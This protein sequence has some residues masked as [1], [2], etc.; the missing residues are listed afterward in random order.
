ME[1]NT[2]ACS[3]ED[4]APRGGGARPV[5][6]RTTTVGRRA[7]PAAPRRGRK[8]PRVTAAAAER[9][10]RGCTARS[11]RARRRVPL[12]GCGAPLL[13]DRPTPSASTSARRAGARRTIAPRSSPSWPSARRLR[14][15][16]G[17]LL[18]VGRATSLLGVA[19]DGNAPVFVQD[20]CSS[21]A[22]ALAP[23]VPS[24]ARVLDA[25]AGRQGALLHAPDAH[26]GARPLGAQGARAAPALALERRRGRAPRRMR[27]RRR[28]GGWWDN[29]PPAR[30]LSTR[31][32]ARRDPRS[33]R[34]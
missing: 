17:V 5:G 3:R 33:S 27:R 12:A 4:A 6:R 18:K 25:C 20:A 16:H 23:F 28:P 13:L 9:A 15:A 29:E 31:R 10:G 32:A 21:G 1:G 11:R 30:L 2:G 22:A 7:A 34:R 26:H 19:G 14:G 8:P 24:N